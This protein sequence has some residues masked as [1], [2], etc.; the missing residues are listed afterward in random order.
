MIEESELHFRVKFA[1]LS[2]PVISIQISSPKKPVG[3][4]KA[5]QA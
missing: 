4:N 1:S 3:R 5:F 2:K